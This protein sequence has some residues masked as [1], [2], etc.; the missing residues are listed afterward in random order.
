MLVMRFL[1]MRLDWQAKAVFWRIFMLK[2][3]YQFLQYD[4]EPLT[5]VRGV[6]GQDLHVTGHI[7][8][9]RFEENSL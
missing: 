7:E 6:A 4:R 5:D 8:E 3:D 1:G 9:D 2:I